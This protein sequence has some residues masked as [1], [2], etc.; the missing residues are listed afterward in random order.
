MEHLTA[1]INRVHRQQ[2]QMWRWKVEGLQKQR[3]KLQ[4]EIERLKEQVKFLTKY[5]ADVDGLQAEN[6]KL[7]MQMKKLATRI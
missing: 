6:E 2:T 7:S 5:D 4:A 1:E 3:D